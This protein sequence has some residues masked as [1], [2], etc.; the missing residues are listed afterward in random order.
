[1]ALAA[2]CTFCLSPISADDAKP[3][4]DAAGDAQLIRG[5]WVVVDL[6]Q[7][8]HEVTKEERE[9]FRKGGYKITITGRTMLHSPDKSEGR[10]RLDTAK[11]P[12]VLEVLD[13]GRVVARAIYELKGDDLKICQ[14]RKPTGGG[15]PVPPADFDIKKA[16]PGTFPT[17]FILR[18]EAAK[19]AGKP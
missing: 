8:N 7:V 4:K 10:Y 9:F 11:R 5:T 16:A 6:Q 19:P 2:G 17:L 3:K 18:R 14:G 15:E 12:R 1:L 13:G